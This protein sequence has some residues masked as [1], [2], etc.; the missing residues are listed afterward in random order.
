[1]TVIY[2]SAILIAIIVGTIYIASLPRAPRR[3]GSSSD[4]GPYGDSGGPGHDSGGG[5]GGTDGGSSGGGDGGGGG[6]GD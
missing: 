6:G 1:M 2:G 5:H 4:S 3:G